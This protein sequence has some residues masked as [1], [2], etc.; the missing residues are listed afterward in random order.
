M[1]LTRLRAALPDLSREQV[2]QVLH[3]LLAD[4]G[5]FLIPESNQKALTPADLAAAVSVGGTD[6]HL[7]AIEPR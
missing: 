3:T 4:P 1:S 6:K 2:D 5:V 7:L